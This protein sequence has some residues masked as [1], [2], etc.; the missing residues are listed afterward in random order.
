LFGEDNLAVGESMTCTAEGTAIKGE[1]TNTGYVEATPLGFEDKVQDSD[2]SAYF[3]AEPAVAI[4]KYTN[5]EDAKEP[6]GPYIP[7]GEPVN[8][9]FEI[10]DTETGRFD[11]EIEVADNS[12]LPIE[13]AIVTGNPGESTAGYHRPCG[14]DG[15]SKQHGC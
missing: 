13:E 4:T 10:N 5:G 14:W 7:V 15:R 2:S 12:D 11:S 1:Y 8:F 6:T 3:G 9:T